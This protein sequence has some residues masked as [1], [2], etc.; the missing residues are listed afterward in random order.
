[1]KHNVTMSLPR[2]AVVGHRR[3]SP[4]I[5]K[6]E[7]EYR[8]KAEIVIYE[9][10]FE[11]ALSLS[12][13]LIAQQ[14][15]DV[16]LTAGAN[17]SFL[18][19]N[20]SVPIATIKVTGYDLMRALVRAR[21][22][23]E[24]IGLVAYRQ[25]MPELEEVKEI[26]RFD[27][28]QRSYETISQ[29]T[30]AIRALGKLGYKVIVGSSITVEVAQQE[31]LVGVLVYSEDSARQGL[32]EAIE[33]G[34]LAR[35]GEARRE[36][37]S[38]LIHN[39]REGLLAV[40]FAGK[41]Q[42]ANPAMERLI[43]TRMEE[44]YKRGIDALAPDFRLH[45]AKPGNDNE[46]ETVVE[47]NGQT[48][49]LSRSPLYE[50]GQH[51]G[52]VFTMQESALIQQSERRLRTYKRATNFRAKNK[53][54]SLEK[55]APSI[56]ETIELG[57]RYA[58]TDST[59]LLTGESGTGK[60]WFAQSIHNHSRRHN[61]PFVPINCAAFPESLLES[62]LFGY[63]EGAF[64]GSR[65]GGKPGLIE[66]A[67]TGTLFLDEIGDM[68]KSLQTRLL[69][70]LQEREVQRLGASDA[71]RVD[72]RIV[73]ATLQPLED[74][75]QEGVFREDLFYRLNVLRIE[76]AP[77]RARIADIAPLARHFLSKTV[78][79]NK[80]GLGVDALLEVLLPHVQRYQWPGN[81][82]ELENILERFA[83]LATT[84]ASDTPIDDKWIMKI[85]PE[86]ARSSF[87]ARTVDYAAMV[88]KY[89]SVAAA[90]KMLNI[91]RTTLWRRLS[92]V[93]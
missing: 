44:L 92:K 72:I 54:A 11:H 17:A 56:K 49:V 36:R 87:Q 64:T 68:P 41:I 40:D 89:G 51:V 65:K 53:F 45:L 71:T 19:E 46:S 15:A 29:A 79:A 63:E 83:V 42:A 90:A 84:L 1:L 78:A 37:L 34:R 80:Q 75:V 10:I 67:H 22:Y 14:R 50:S 32:N 58:V 28:A 4:L 52:S 13:R 6:L 61:G 60:E 69:R 70:V 73:A 35:S 33:L 7:P 9:D 85:A 31:G 62:E 21:E 27:I 26:F 2:I 20:S 5:R 23:D 82:R 38:S 74:L 16:I 66:L 47:L 93:S 59:I 39:L 55:Y 30:S 3:L 76:I 81:I 24:R 86:L 91:S 57:K 18:R 48:V 88:E 12:E 43:G 8:G 77:L 25:I